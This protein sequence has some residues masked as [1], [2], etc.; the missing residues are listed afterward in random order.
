T[1]AGTFAHAARVQA[2]LLFDR[3]V[4][5]PWADAARRGSVALDRAGQNEFRHRSHFGDY[6]IDCEEVCAGDVQ[7]TGR[8]NPRR[9]RDAGVGT[10]R[11]GWC[12]EELV[13]RSTNR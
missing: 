9:G 3:T 7:Q 1:E 8:G 6:R 5:V 2:G 12:A 11:L 4:A 10:A 13:E